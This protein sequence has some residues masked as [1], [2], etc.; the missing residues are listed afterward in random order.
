LLR[1]PAL[2]AY[3]IIQYYGTSEWEFEQKVEVK[4]YSPVRFQQLLQKGSAP[5][6]EIRPCFQSLLLPPKHKGKGQLQVNQTITRTKSP[7]RPFIQII[8]SQSDSEDNSAIP[9][10]LVNIPRWM[11]QQ[12]ADVLNNATHWVMASHRS[13]IDLAIDLQPGSPQPPYLKMYN[14]S[15]RESEA[16]EEWLTEHLAKGHIWESTSPAGAPVVFSPKKNGQ[17]RICVDY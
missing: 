12:Y 10:D 14:I 7:P 3:K 2:V 15:P 11:R 9:S 17:L 13:G 8:G 16:L 4:E 1:R 6:Y 5:V